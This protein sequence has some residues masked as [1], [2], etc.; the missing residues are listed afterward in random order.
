MPSEV[1]TN[2]NNMK[3]GLL[4]VL[5]AFALLGLFFVI[6]FHVP[7]KADPK[8]PTSVSDLGSLRTATS[9]IKPPKAFHY[10][11]TA[12]LPTAEASV[13]NQQDPMFSLLEKQRAHPSGDPKIDIV[14]QFDLII[15]QKLGSDFPKAKHDLISAAQWNMLTE[16][17]KLLAELDRGHITSEQYEKQ[18]REII[19]RMGQEVAKSLTDDEYELLFDIDKARPL[20]SILP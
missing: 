8:P 5:G 7:Q 18:H 16:N 12:S 2:N 6:S 4:I 17:E 11:D 13:T 19:D 20:S 14:E 10:K 15:V 3:R 9:S 1:L